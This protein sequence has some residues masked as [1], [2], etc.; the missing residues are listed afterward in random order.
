MEH[1]LAS[2]IAYIGVF[3]LGA[4][5]GSFANVCI[6]RLPRTDEFPEGRSIVSPGSHCFACKEPVAWYDNV[7][8]LSYL[9]LRGRCRNCRAEFSPR[10]LFVEAATAMIFVALYQ[11]CL[12]DIHLDQPVETRMIRAGIYALFAFTLIVIT[13]IDLD[14][15][16]ILNVITFPAI[17][18]FYALAQLLPETHPIDGLIGAAVGYGVVWL[19][20]NSYGL[21]RGDYGF[22]AAIDGGALRVEDVEEGE[23]ADA[24]GLEVGDRIAAINGIDLDAEGPEAAEPFFET[25]RI[26]RGARLELVVE[27]GG[28][29][30]AIEIIAGP[31]LGMGYGDGK[32]LAVVGALLGWQGVVF[33]LFAGAVIGTALN[34]PGLIL[35][36][37]RGR[38]GEDYIGHVEIPFGPALAAAALIFLFVEPW[39][40]IQLSPVL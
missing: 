29:R 23:R 21:I 22:D 27:R 16:Q 11:L 3:A 5:F 26:R 31:R 39:L 38:H 32:L 7:P 25:R 2:P 34:L 19:I 14:T 18:V 24:A 6:Y 35:D 8:L 4:V 28:E 12:H 37:L 17:P 40:E 20:A 10:Y 33:A 36:K 15:F 13:F 1:V 30:S 9:W